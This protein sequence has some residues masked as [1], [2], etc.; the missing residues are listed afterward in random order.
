LRPPADVDPVV[1]QRLVVR[2]GVLCSLPDG[3]LRLAPHWCSPLA[4]CAEVVAVIQEAVAE[5]RGA[6]A[7]M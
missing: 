7:T 2:R 5:A 3:L 4:E 1:L 6:A